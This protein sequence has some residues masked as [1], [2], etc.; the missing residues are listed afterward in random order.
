MTAEAPRLT[1]FQR[2][3]VSTD[4]TVTQLLEIYAG[5]AVEVVK[6]AQVLDTAGDGDV[7][8]GP[9][10]DDKVLRRE[11]L[12]VGAASGRV[13]LHAR[14]VVAIARVDATLVDALMAT[15]TPLGLLLA[16]RRTETFREVLQV[17]R[18]PAAG[19]ARH[20]GVSATD[21]VVGR[22]YRLMAGGV[23]VALVK[24][25]FPVASYRDILG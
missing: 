1:R 19:L 16:E 6:L 25:R 11:V 17:D 12:L 3:L 21:E 2:M 9:L 14:A 8:L 5:E 24:E 15:D 23:P 20:F 7:E 13:L 4:G 22:T 18:E 10:A